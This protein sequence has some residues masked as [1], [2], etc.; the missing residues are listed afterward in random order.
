MKERELK[1]VKSGDDTLITNAPTDIF[2]LIYETL[3][4]IKNK[5][6]K[7]VYEYFLIIVK[8]IVMNYLISIDYIL[9]VNSNE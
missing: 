8:E 2:K 6:T 9:S 7:A 1:A 3:D 4:L 5:K